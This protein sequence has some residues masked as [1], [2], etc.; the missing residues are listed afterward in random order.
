M[1]GGREANSREDKEVLRSYED[2]V[3]LLIM[4]GRMGGK[5]ANG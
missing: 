1:L 3:L 4:V 2:K 5:R